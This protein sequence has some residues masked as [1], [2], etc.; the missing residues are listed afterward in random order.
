MTDIPDNARRAREM[1]AAGATARAIR[2]ATGLSTWKIYF[3]IDGGPKAEG[4]PLLPPLPRRNNVA[5]RRPFRDD[6]VALVG[7]MMIAAE[8]QV[9]E[10]EARLA[11][12]G[13]PPD[14]A[15][16]ARTLAVL[17][18]TMRELIAVD[19]LRRGG[20]QRVK[21]QERHDDPVPRD[22]DELRRRLARRLDE[23]VAESKRVCPDEA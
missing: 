12:E 21:K 19:S 11:G 23:L 17:A 5:R 8:A 3:W 1:Y 13:A 16:D 7:R 15:R 9:R 10:I 20:D 4:V 22:V 18:R 2:E 6:R 14:R